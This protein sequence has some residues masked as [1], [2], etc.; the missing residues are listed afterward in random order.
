MLTVGALLAGPRPVYAGD[1]EPAKLQFYTTTVKPILQNNCY[2]CHGGMN[3]RAG[4]QMET[5]A[6]LLTGG[7]HGPALVPGSP[8][9]SLLIHLIRHEE[10]Q[11]IDPMPPRGRLTD[12]EV[13]AVTRWIHDGAVM[14]R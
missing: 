7:H 1:D 5:R 8:E 12:A 11:G 14:D 9:Q 10:A 13:A 2:R 6:Q 4:L 3:R